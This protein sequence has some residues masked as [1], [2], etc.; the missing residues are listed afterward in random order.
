MINGVELSA[1]DSVPKSHF[2]FIHFQGNF[3][4]LTG[5]TLGFKHNQIHRTII[6]DYPLPIML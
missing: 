1:L 3:A 4:C 6:I 2:V 5:P